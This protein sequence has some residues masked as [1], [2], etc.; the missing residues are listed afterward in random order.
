MGSGVSKRKRMLEAQVQND[1][2]F[3]R[4]RAQSDREPQTR[5]DLQTAIEIVGPTNSRTYI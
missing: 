3:S 4:A 5:N 2:L 1:S